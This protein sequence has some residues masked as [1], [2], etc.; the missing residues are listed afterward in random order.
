VN[1]LPRRT[2][3]GWLRAFDERAA[4]WSHE[5]RRR[6]RAIWRAIMAAADNEG[7]F[8]GNIAALTDAA[9]DRLN[10]DVV[11]LSGCSLGRPDQRIE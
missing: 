2:T 6:W 4:A 11:R 8:H 9:S 10:S 1:P 3:D 5:R 7:Y